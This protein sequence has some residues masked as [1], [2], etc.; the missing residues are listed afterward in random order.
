MDRSHPQN[1]T[2]AEKPKFRGLIAYLY[3][4][5]LA[6]SPYYSN[7]ISVSAIIPFPRWAEKIYKCIKTRYGHLW[8]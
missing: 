4:F 3:Y 6:A 1:L 8:A 7:E 2:L 5:C